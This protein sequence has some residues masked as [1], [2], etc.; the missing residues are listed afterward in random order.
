M[1]AAR[2]SCCRCLV[3]RV[4][5][6]GPP[7]GVERQ[8]PRPAT[9]RR[10]RVALPAVAR[11][12]YG[13]RQRA[14]R[15]GRAFAARVPSLAPCFNP[16]M[17]ADAEV[18]ARP[19]GNL[20]GMPAC[21]ALDVLSGP[22]LARPAGVRGRLE[23]SAEKLARHDRGGVPSADPPLA[24]REN[25]VA[26][27]GGES[28]LARRVVH[29]GERTRLCRRSGTPAG[30]SAWLGLAV[31]LGHRGYALPAAWRPD[32]SCCGLGRSRADAGEYSRIATRFATR[33]HGV[34]TNQRVDSALLQFENAP[35]PLGGVEPPST[36]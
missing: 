6:S 30:G 29:G 31:A 4:P 21:G 7:A 22:G 35:V 18:S 12:A 23:Q 11:G 8:G 16:C 26:G 24:P 17:T 3:T 28:V 34:P 25:R 10:R 14:R 20:E 5:S 2:A 1:P 13:E 15:A 32:A 9:D 33:A 19:L 27:A 36:G